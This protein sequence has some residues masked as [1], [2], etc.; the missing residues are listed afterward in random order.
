MTKT[1]YNLEDVSFCNNGSLEV[2]LSQN[3]Y[4]YTVRTF[5][6]TYM[7]IREAYDGLLEMIPLVVG[8]TFK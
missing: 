6:Y 2:F 7:L 8:V 4:I 5:T 1:E 3:I